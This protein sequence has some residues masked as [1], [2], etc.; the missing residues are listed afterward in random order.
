MCIQVRRPRSPHVGYPA[1]W[2]ES[3]AAS[4]RHFTYFGADADTAPRYTSGVCF[5]GRAP[6]WTAVSL[7]R[8]NAYTLKR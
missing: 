3:L 6:F 8:L 1:V 5:A 7:K 2:R 4:G